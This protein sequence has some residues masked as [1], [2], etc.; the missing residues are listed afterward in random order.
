MT[1]SENASPGMPGTAS[2]LP[3]LGACRGPPPRARSGWLQVCVRL[4]GLYW[5]TV[6]FGIGHEERRA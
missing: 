2:G 4:S 3:A 5:K 1:V 6:T